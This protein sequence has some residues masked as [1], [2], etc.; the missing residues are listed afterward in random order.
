VIQF[1]VAGVIAVIV[2]VYGA[3]WLSERA[4]T[5]EAIV[6]AR[7]TTE[8][9]AQSVAEPEIR[10][11]LVWLQSSALDR[12]D[13]IAVKRLL[14]GDVLRVKIWDEN[15][16]ILYSDKT[17]LIGETFPLGDEEQEILRNGGT[18]AEVSDLSRPENR[19]DRG[20]GGRLL[21]VYT[22]IWSPNGHPLLFEAYYSYDI[23]TERSAD[24]LA[25][26]RP[27]T[28]AGLLIFIALTVPLV[29][30]LARRLDRAAA[31]RERLLVAAV[32]ASDAE[33]RRIA[34][35]LHDGVVQDLAGL[36][37]AASAT[38]RELGDRP[39][40]AQR[41]E[42][43]GGG[44]RHSLRVLRSLLVEIYPPELRTE[45]LAAALDDLVAP[46]IASGVQVHLDVEGTDGARAE[47]IALVWRAAQEAVRNAL[48][49]GSPSTMN[50]A[51]ASDGEHLSLV[52]EDDGVGFDPGQTPRNGHLGL[53]GLRD[54][55]IEMNGS[56]E[57]DSAP[58]EG[59]RVKMEVAR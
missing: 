5:D 24:I 3:T 41:L 15:G 31:E 23:V 19:F 55:I 29:W 48:R 11:G 39:D 7:A 42:A 49:H 17:Q 8:I 53:R 13:R 52:V 4:A 34:R 6:D 51:V 57:I 22:R 59:T 47:S 2:L 25:S 1:S 12:F 16:Q 40:L 21:E 9:L 32:E 10:P 35:D 45:G 56:F 28:V 18:D 44:V 26:F 33:R 27:I 43:L 20:F 54:L 37:F 38:A 36:S 46:A 30:V 14:V 50:I 58:G